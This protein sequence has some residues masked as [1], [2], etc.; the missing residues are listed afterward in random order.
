MA[1]PCNPGE[2]CLFHTHSTFC[3]RCASNEI[4]PDGVACTACPSDTE[5]NV[6]QTACISC[7][8]GKQS[9]IGLC[10]TCPSGKFGAGGFC[11]TCPAFQE[12]NE[13]ATRCQCQTGFYRPSHGAV[14]E[15]GRITCVERSNTHKDCTAEQQLAVQ[16]EECPACVSCNGGYALIQSGFGLSK[17]DAELYRSGL[18]AN[19]WVT[20]AVYECPVGLMCEGEA[21]KDSNASSD[22]LR[23]IN[24]REGHDPLSPMCAVCLPDWIKGDKKLCEPCKEKTPTL[25]D[26]VKL[27]VL[28]VAVGLGT[29][30]VKYASKKL[31]EATKQRQ[32]DEYG[33]EVVIVGTVAALAPFYVYLKVAVRSNL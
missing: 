32:T 19:S 3:D 31:E 1:N 11:N 23:K 25:S 10:T 29:L 18:S 4:G 16:C 8:A 20:Q 14:W 30:C 9:L 27:F 33:T 2:S 24:C 13:A 7:P 26:F 17:K 6:L 21:F 22:F 15:A 5:P 28:I 12:P